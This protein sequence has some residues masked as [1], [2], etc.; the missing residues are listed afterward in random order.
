[1]R[2]QTLFPVEEELVTQ[3]RRVLAMRDCGR[4]LSGQAGLME[5][6]PTNGQPCGLL[7]DELWPE[8][9]EV[10]EQDE[11]HS[12]VNALE[13]LVNDPRVFTAVVPAQRGPL[14]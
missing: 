10:M 1:V 7:S 13:T 14:D 9:H 11:F 4:C 8:E 3:E 6:C 2:T 12:L 5:I